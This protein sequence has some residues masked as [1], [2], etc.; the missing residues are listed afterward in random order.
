MNDFLQLQEKVILIADAAS[1]I[2]GAALRMLAGQGAKAVPCSAEDFSSKERIEALFSRICGDPALGRIDGLFYNLLPAPARIGI[3]D[4]TEKDFD[5]AIDGYITSC[6]LTAQLLGEQIRRQ[7]EAVGHIRAFDGGSLVFLNSIHSEKPNG[8]APL[9]SMCMGAVKNLVRE[10]TLFYGQWGLRATLIEPGATGGEDELFYAGTSS[11]YNGYQYKIPDGHVGTPDD[12]AG[13]ACFLLSSASRYVNGESIRADGGLTLH[14]IDHAANVREYMKRGMERE[15]GIAGPEDQKAPSG[16][17]TMPY[18]DHEK[19]TRPDHV[20]GTID[21][22]FLRGKTVLVTGSGKGIGSDIALTAA[23]H[24]ANVVVHYNSSEENAR[25]VYAEI[26]RTAPASILVRADL[27]ERGGAQKLYDAA[28][29][30]FGGVDVLVNNAALQYNLELGEYDAEHLQKIFRV[31][32]RGY[33]MMSR[34]VL[35]HMREKGWGRIV[36]MSSVHGKRPTLFD[37]GYCMTKGGIKM[38]VR[39]LAID[40]AEDDITVNALEPGAVEIGVKSGNPQPTVR[41]LEMREPP[42]FQ[43]AGRLVHGRMAN[44]W[45]ISSTVMYL[46]SDEA[47]RINGVAIRIDDAGMLR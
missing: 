41:H 40:A 6:F 7:E 17:F 4:L 24:G 18:F 16:P 44:P 21:P 5:A 32:L 2:G 30:A 25:R 26:D 9:F 22:M 45:D 43:Y 46:L 20:P 14:Y 11:L 42:L 27:S 12:I 33:A 34:L 36:C 13:I 31:N 47:F 29:E 38:L 3:R 37:P 8:A 39:E 19:Q 15:R 1:P 35:P 23:Q 28:V 10:I